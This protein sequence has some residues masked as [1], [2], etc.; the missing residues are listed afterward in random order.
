MSILTKQQILG[1]SKKLRQKTI[2]FPELGGEILFQEMSYADWDA[3]DKKAPLYALRLFAAS[4]VDEKGVRLF[5]EEDANQ[6]AARGSHLIERGA[7]AVLE[8]NGLLEESPG[9]I[10]K[11][12]PKIPTPP[13][14]GE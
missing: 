5:S 1:Q 13:A 14:T 7:R 2:P 4:A 12:S 9:A 8:L 6:L 11:N 3:F 10:L